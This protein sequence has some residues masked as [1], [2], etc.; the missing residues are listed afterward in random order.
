MTLLLPMI[1]KRRKNC[2]MSTRVS[3]NYGNRPNSLGQ[4]LALKDSIRQPL[5]II[6]L[7][8]LNNTIWHGT[9]ATS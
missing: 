8:H 6:L 1:P 3:S 5:L 7:P 9:D 2:E 4:K